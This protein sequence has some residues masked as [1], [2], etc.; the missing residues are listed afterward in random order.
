MSEQAKAP[1]YALE[2]FFNALRAALILVGLLAFPGALQA[3][4]VCMLFCPV[5][6]LNCTLVFDADGSC[7]CKCQTFDFDRVPD[8]A[9]LTNSPSTQEISIGRAADGKNF[10]FVPTTPGARQSLQERLR[11][12]GRE[13]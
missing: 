8:D 2:G 11:V 5:G 4:N 10:T 3:R 9:Y 13:Q 12:L 7:T 6:M 1:K